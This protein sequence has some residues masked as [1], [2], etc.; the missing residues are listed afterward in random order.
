MNYGFRFWSFFLHDWIL[1]VGYS[2]F[3]VFP[4]IWE[5]PVRFDEPQKTRLKMKQYNRSG[6][7]TLVITLALLA[8]L[9]I[10]G[11]TMI[12][13]AR[14]DRLAARS[15]RYNTQMNLAADASLEWFGARWAEEYWNREVPYYSSGTNAAT[16]KPFP[17]PTQWNSYDVSLPG[18]GGTISSRG[19]SPYDSD[20]LI[21]QL[22]TTCAITG[23][24]T[25][26]SVARSAGTNTCFNLSALVKAEP[27]VTNVPVAAWPIVNPGSESYVYPEL[28]FPAGPN[29]TIEVSLTAVDLDARLNLNF[30]GSYIPTGAGLSPTVCANW[31]GDSIQQVTPP[32]NYIPANVLGNIIAGTTGIGRYG[33]S[34][35]ASNKTAELVDGTMNPFAPGIYAGL[36]GT[37]TL[38]GV[39]SPGILPLPYNLEDL[40]ELL[41]ISGPTSATGLGTFCSRLMSQATNGTNY[42]LGTP[43]AYTN[44]QKLTRSLVTTHSW[45]SAARKYFYYPASPGAPGDTL[46]GLGGLH[47]KADL[48]CAPQAD[49]EQALLATRMFLPSNTGTDMAVME[50]IVANIID[51]RRECIPIPGASSPASHTGPAG[52]YIGHPTALTP[53]AGSG[54]S[55]TGGQIYGVQRQPYINE[56]FVKLKDTVGTP[57]GTT[58]T[59]HKGY[60]WDVFIEL[61]NPYDQPLYLNQEF[62]D[63]WIGDDDTVPTYNDPDLTKCS[64]LGTLPPN[65]IGIPAAPAPGQAGGCVIGA[66]VVSD[67]RNSFATIVKQLQPIRLINTAYN[68]TG[69]TSTPILIDRMKVVVPPSFTTSTQLA[70]NTTSCQRPTYNNSGAALSHAGAVLNF[71][72]GYMESPPQ[73]P[74][75]P[76]SYDQIATATTAMTGAL[77]TSYVLKQLVFNTVATGVN[78]A[79][80]VRPVEN[81]SR[82]WYNKNTNS[83]I[84]TRAYYPPWAQAPSATNPELSFACPGDLCR[85]LVIGPGFGYQSGGSWSAGGTL[86][87]ISG[88]QSTAPAAPTG[89]MIWTVTEQLGATV[90]TAAPYECDMHI[91]LAGISNYT[92]LP[93]NKRGSVSGGAPYEWRRLI[94][95]FN[96]NSPYYDGLDNSGR[97]QVVD[98]QATAAVA[99]NSA[100]AVV[101]ELYEHGRVNLL[102]APSEVI[103]GLIAPLQGYVS[104]T[105]PTTTNLTTPATYN[106]FR[107][108]PN[109]SPTP[110]KSPADIL[111]IKNQWA[112][113][114][115]AN[116]NCDDDG[117]GAFNDYAKRCWL[118]TFIS[119]WA[120]IRSDCVAVYGTVRLM[121][122]SVS[123]TVPQG[124]RHFV[125]VMDRVPATAFQPI[126][127]VPAGALVKPNPFYQPPRR[128]LL[129]WLD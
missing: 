62:T 89:P 70:G 94:D 79:Y 38:P 57:T 2:I 42:Y 43:G 22:G 78:A 39:A 13:M 118:Y 105:N 34:G 121:D 82:T 122:S 97:G 84:R 102:T 117:N 5:F 124:L 54:I 125:A 104:K 65:T 40:S 73:N 49:L 114:L 103:Q 20:S 33:A 86:G 128:L 71:F 76:N 45:T 127:L 100:A 56:V 8:A 80:T 10:I 32:T 17:Q 67:S 53:T 96:V 99:S 108:Y 113:T 30:T 64:T 87:F 98:Y 93:V 81:R 44:V 11:T 9:A 120:T 77:D 90:P 28:R 112:Q 129:T 75:S 116:S 18:D 58:S 25:V 101:G 60:K 29:K 48:N 68:P 69:G 36:A 59:G 110:W 31:R 12:S 15:N 6:G 63:L 55:V 74:V 66:V 106:G 3:A 95:V 50:Q 126:I 37:A 109:G 52:A 4:A 46:V 88:T 72:G 19:D 41:N 61:A 1:S 16:A 51:Y 27:T 21:S 14:M 26:N 123:T 24:P 7:T 91:D 85:L 23:P 47:V 111:D 92:S 83:P 107:Q 119:N 115:F 35:G